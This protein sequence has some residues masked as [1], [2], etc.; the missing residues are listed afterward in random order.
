MQVFTKITITKT[1]TLINTFT[2]NVTRL[3]NDYY[4]LFIYIDSLNAWWFGRSGSSVNF[5]QFRIFVLFNLPENNVL[6]RFPK[7]VGLCR[8]YTCSNNQT[9]RASRGRLR[10]QKTVPLIKR[11][12]TA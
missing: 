6:H 11:A 8:W 7:S 2:W 4:T 12:G 3:E 9:I 10:K 1:L 5:Y